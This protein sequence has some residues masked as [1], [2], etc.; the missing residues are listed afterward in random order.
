MRLTDPATFLLL[1]ED[2]EG[3]RLLIRENLKAGGL[4]CRVVEMPDGREA[5]DYLFRRGRYQEPAKSPRPSVILLDIRMPRAD[6]FAV[7]EKVKAD[8][9]LR[10]LPVIMLTST[11]DQTEVNRCYALGANSYVVKSVRYE[12]FQERVRA[13]GAFL[14]MVWLAE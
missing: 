9:E 14:N 10:H 2:D 12:E 4:A 7:L 8:P 13:L 1:V 11:D 5:L 3:H 6:G